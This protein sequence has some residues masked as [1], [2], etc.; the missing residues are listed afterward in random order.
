VVRAEA[1]VTG[2]A[3]LYKPKIA[4]ERKIERRERSERFSDPDAPRPAKLRGAAAMPA[5]K[6]KPG[7]G[8]RSGA[9]VPRSRPGTGSPTPRR[10]GTGSPRPLSKPA[11]ARKAAPRKPS[12]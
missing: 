6:A 10:P 5:P 9:P 4:K 2:E 8:P 7:A 11:G 3:G 12:K 1:G